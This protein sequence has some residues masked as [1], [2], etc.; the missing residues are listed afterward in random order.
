MKNKRLIKVSSWIGKAAL[1]IGML[2]AV[3]SGYA[4]GTYYYQATAGISGG[5]KVYVSDTE[6]NSPVYQDNPMTITGG[7]DGIAL[8]GGGNQTLHFYASNNE[9]YRFTGWKNNQGTIVS[10]NTH[11]T[12]PDLWVSGS[13]DWVWDGLFSGHYDYSNATQITYTAMFEAITGYVQVYSSD[14]TRGT[15]DCSNYDNTLNE[16]ITIM[17]Y[18][19]ASKGIK[20]LGWKKTNSASASYV[21]TDNPYTLTVTG[22]ERYYAFFSE[23]ATMVYCI[24]KNRKTGRYLSFYGNGKVSD[25]TADVVYS[26]ISVNAKDGFVF[27]NGLKMISE[28][29]A[30]G[31]PMTVFKR[32][33]TKINGSL[34]EGDLATDVKMPY[35]G[36][37]TAVSI[38]TLLESTNY[39]LTFEHQ[40]DGSYKIYANYTTRV[41]IGLTPYDIPLQSCLYDDGSSDFATLQA[42]DNMNA[43]NQAKAYWDIYFLTEEQVEGAFGA[44]AKA[45]FTQENKYYTTMYAPFAYRLLDGVTAYYLPFSSESYN[46]E[47]NKLIFKEIA[48]GSVVPANTAV[49]L[50]CQNSDDPTKN[51]L[52]PVSEATPITGATNQLLKGYTLLY[53]RASNGLINTV[54]NSDLR[55]ILSMNDAGKLGFYHYSG[56]NMNPN[57]A[58]LELPAPLDHL[59][60]ALNQSVGDLAKTFSFSFGE[61]TGIELSPVVVDDADAPIYDLQGRKIENPSQGIYVK[62]GKKFVVK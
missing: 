42:I 28:S 32:T 7:T 43:D 20:F 14:I 18:P 15:V 51:R 58:F 37:N 11:Y 35:N 56:S 13:R 40:S 60:E 52:L 61:T 46:Q 33:S 47:K 19:D 59:A 57:K 48:S 39:P 4:S 5:G 54:A 49:I 10:N 38:A 55:Y 6:T 34:E 41:W 50:E 23:P 2:F 25:H 44:N 3:L 27:D 26:G 9:G 36:T 29:S 1:M 45:K 62:K 17:A 31:N 24:L 12:A 30:L 21:T 8:L 53:S 22:S 16:E